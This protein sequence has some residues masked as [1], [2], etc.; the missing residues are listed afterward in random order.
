MDKTLTRLYAYYNA[1][2]KA[3][4]RVALAILILVIGII[5]AR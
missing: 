2:L 5:V 1:F 3:I 4:P